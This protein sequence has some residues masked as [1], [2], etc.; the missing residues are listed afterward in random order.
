M[1]DLWPRS[2]HL[3][4]YYLIVGISNLKCWRLIRLLDLSLQV[5]ANGCLSRLTVAVRTLTTPPQPSQP[6]NH[7]PLAGVWSTIC[8]ETLLMITG[9]ESR[10]LKISCTSGATITHHDVQPS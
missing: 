8:T 4:I 1:N 3:Y 6:L 5:T 7:P 9:L 2:I 10:A